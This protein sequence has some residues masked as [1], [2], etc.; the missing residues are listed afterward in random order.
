MKGPAGAIDYCAENSED[1]MSSGKV[2]MRS[3]FWLMISWCRV[4][5]NFAFWTV[6]T[7][8]HVQYMC[9]KMLIKYFFR[10]MRSSHICSRALHA[11]YLYCFCSMLF[12]LGH[13]SSIIMHRKFF[14]SIFIKYSIDFSF[15]LSCFLF[16]L[17]L[18]LTLVLQNLIWKGETL[19]FGLYYANLG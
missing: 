1:L 18:Q 13:F 10:V 15:F 5:V 2:W 9:V 17:K 19:F 7:D 11:F 6:Y 16:F 14:L 8:L 3:S 4:I 12:F